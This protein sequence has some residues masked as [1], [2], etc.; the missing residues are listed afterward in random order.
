MEDKIIELFKLLEIKEKDYPE[1]SDPISFANGFKMCS[2]Y[3][4][5]DISTSNSTCEQLNKN[6]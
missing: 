6:T 3:E 4:N 2:L 5:S 1:Y